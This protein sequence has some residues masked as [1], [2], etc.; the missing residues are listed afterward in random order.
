MARLTDKD[1]ILKKIKKAIFENRKQN[2]AQLGNYYE[3]SI[4]IY[5]STQAAYTLKEA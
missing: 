1:I 3:H 2:I 4:A 5:T